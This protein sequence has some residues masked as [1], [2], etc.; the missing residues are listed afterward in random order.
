MLTMIVVT[1]SEQVR[2]G[3]PIN[4]NCAPS[5]P[6]RIGFSSV[7]YRS[8]ASP[9]GR[10]REYADANHFLAHIVVTVFNH[11]FNVAIGCNPLPTFLAISIILRLRA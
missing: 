2:A 7:Q 11:Q 8:H 1:A 6:P 5:V 4:D 3:N 9:A 10:Y